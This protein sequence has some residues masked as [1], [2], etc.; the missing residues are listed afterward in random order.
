MH[1]HVVLSGARTLDDKVG[2]TM[3][4]HAIK[5]R[6]GPDG[7]TFPCKVDMDNGHLDIYEPESIEG[8]QIKREMDSGESVVK[9]MLK[10]KYASL[11]IDEGDD[12]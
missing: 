6:F 1:A 7:L 10:A 8:K 12:N 9:Q 5:N 11:S 4:I 3:R 2:N